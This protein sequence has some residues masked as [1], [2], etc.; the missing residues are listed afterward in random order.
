MEPSTDP[1][2]SAHAATPSTGLR[3]GASDEIS[4]GAWRRWRS[5]FYFWLVVALMLAIAAAG[6]F[7]LRRLGVL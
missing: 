7:N 2:D 5:R 6:W 4:T 1:P 3:A